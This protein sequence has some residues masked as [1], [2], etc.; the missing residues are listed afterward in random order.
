MVARS[1][2]S[3]DPGLGRSNPFSG[4]TRDEWNS[5]E[6]FYEIGGVGRN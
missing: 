6:T 3:D 4:S 1:N 2:H 5:K